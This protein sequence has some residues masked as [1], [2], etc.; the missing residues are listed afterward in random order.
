MYRIAKASHHLGLNLYLTIDLGT[1]MMRSQIMIYCQ[2]QTTY[3]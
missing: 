1:E 3:M 2:V